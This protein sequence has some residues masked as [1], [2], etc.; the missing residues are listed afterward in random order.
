[1]WKLPS[2]VNQTMVHLCRAHL[3]ENCDTSQECWK[4]SGPQKSRTHSN[5]ISIYSNVSDENYISFV[6]KF[7]IDFKSRQLAKIQEQLH[8]GKFHTIYNLIEHILTL[9]GFLSLY[10]KCISKSSIWWKPFNG[11]EERETVV[12]FF[13]AIKSFDQH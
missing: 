4:Q 9:I 12:I 1:M 10:R 13:F 11:T 7:F 5:V 6:L 8:D 3:P 2:Q